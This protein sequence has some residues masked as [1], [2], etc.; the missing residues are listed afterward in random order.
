MAAGEEAHSPSRQP[1]PLVGTTLDNGCREPEEEEERG[2]EIEAQRN[3]YYV[4][5][6]TC[7]DRDAQCRMD[8][9]DAG[10]EAVVEDGCAAG[11]AKILY[12]ESMGNTSEE[13]WFRDAYLDQFPTP[14][15]L[16]E[17]GAGGDGD[18]E[19]DADGVEAE[20]EL[21]CEGAGERQEGADHGS[22][23]ASVAATA[24]D[25]PNADLEAGM[26]QDPPVGVVEDEPKPWIVP[27][28][29]VAG[30]L[31]AEREDAGVDGGA[32]TWEEKPVLRFEDSARTNGLLLSRSRDSEP[33]LPELWS[34]GA[35]TGTKRESP[36]QLPPGCTPAAKRECTQFSRIE[37][38]RSEE[39]EAEV[40]A[41]THEAEEELGEEDGIVGLGGRLC[42]LDDAAA[43]GARA[44]CLLSAC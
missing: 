17:R 14:N 41:A 16:A 12:F 26:G 6:T 35:S 29:T 19:R 3:E 28:A 33:S 13:D 2:G 11:Q 23:N 40:V 15:E 7:N 5:D 20:M 37:K 10:G 18:A 8:G 42:A 1:S 34:G 4:G 38:N 44:C 43:H 36:L 25:A 9:A 30:S 27:G 22:A 31:Q 24:P 21:E 32:H 39:P